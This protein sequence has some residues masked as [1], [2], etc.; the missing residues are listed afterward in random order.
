MAQASGKM[1]NRLFGI[2]IMTLALA[3]FILS[4]LAVDLPNAFVS[5]KSPKVTMLEFSTPW[6]LSCIKMKPHV[7]KLEKEM[8]AKLHVVYINM[9]KPESQKYVS[10]FKIESA[11]AFIL[12]NSK[13]KQIYRIEREIAFPE[14]K[15]L[16]TKAMQ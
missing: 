7:E 15:A 6:C 13:G 4:A 14:L 5:N 1:R 2:V 3:G 11:P 10:Q 9:D 8:G 12:F 16:I